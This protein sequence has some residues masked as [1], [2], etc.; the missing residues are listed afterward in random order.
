MNGLSYITNHVDQAFDRLKQDFKD[1]GNFKSLI[2]VFTTRAQA[3]EDAAF[4]VIA[5]R[6]LANATGYTLD[7]LG[8]RVGKLRPPYGAAATDDDVYRVLIYAQI[9]INTSSGT[10]PDFYN[11]LGALGLKNVRVYPVYPASL[12]INYTPN[13]L[14][15]SCG[16]IRSVLESASHPIAFDLVAHEATGAFGFAGDITASG[17]DAGKIGESR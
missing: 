10:I 11:I 7:Q 1:V 9:A 17:F 12:T 14:S 15:L 4:P 5:G 6:Y 13:S 8:E 3:F 2:N 16:C